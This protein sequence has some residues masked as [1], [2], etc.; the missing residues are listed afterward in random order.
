MNLIQVRASA[1]KIVWKRSSIGL[2]FPQDALRKVGAIFFMEC[3]IRL[4]SA[5]LKDVILK[6]KT[7]GIVA[8]QSKYPT[9]ALTHPKMFEYFKADE[10]NFYFVPAVESSKLII[11]N[12]W[13]MHYKIMYP[14]IK[15]VLVRSCILPIGMI[16]FKSS[17]STNWGNDL[18]FIIFPDFYRCA[19]FGMPV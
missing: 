12:T 11:F 17:T 2:L 9:T 18:H 8:W 3:H 13:N 5:N 19:K 16:S 4:L 15:C 1:L 6:A 10:E 7:N 14:W